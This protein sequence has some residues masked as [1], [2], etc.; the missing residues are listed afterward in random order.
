METARQVRTVVSLRNWL[1]TVDLDFHEG[2]SLLSL[3]G[4]VTLEM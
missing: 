1:T 4:W 3:L 2:K